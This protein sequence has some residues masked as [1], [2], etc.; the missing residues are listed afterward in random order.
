VATPIEQE[1]NGVGNQLYLDLLNT[2][3]GQLTLVSTFEVGTN[4]DIAPGAD[5]E[6]S[7]ARHAQAARGKD[8]K[9]AS[10]R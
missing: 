1:L 3:D 7:P 8:C 2:N 10:S 4:L 9:E 5:A 6:Q